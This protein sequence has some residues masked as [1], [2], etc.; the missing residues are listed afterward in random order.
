MLGI[1]A[2]LAVAGSVAQGMEQ[3]RQAQEQN[4]QYLDNAKVAANSKSE[5]ERQNNARQTQENM[6]AVQKQFEANVAAGELESTMGLSANESGA[7]GR[8]MG[9][10]LAEAEA[11]SLRDQDKIEQNKLWTLSSLENEKKAYESQYRNQR[12]SVK[13]GK[14]ADW[15]TIGLEI[16]GTAAG[17][18]ASASQAYTDNT[19]KAGGDSKTGKTDKVV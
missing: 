5:K 18:A 10:L 1:S 2:A 6:A 4:K 16:A 8:S 11:E 7:T 3:D 12:N 17:G 19:K 13:K 15:T 14:G 9:L